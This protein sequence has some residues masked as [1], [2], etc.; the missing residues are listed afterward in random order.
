MQDVGL[1]PNVKSYTCLISANGKQKKMCDM[2]SDAFLKMKKVGIQP[3]SHSY[4]ALIHAYSISGWHEKAYAAYESMQREG[5]K[6]SIE[7]Y[8]ALL[9][10]FRRAG[11]VAE[12]G[13][14]RNY[15]KRCVASI[16]LNQPKF[17]LSN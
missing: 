1:K 7:T 6:P 13:E 11:D 10:A 14:L 17:R 2:A 12:I 5:I 3:T 4:T 9:D 16:V 8:T 15:Y